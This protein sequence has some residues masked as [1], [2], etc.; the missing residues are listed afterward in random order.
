MAGEIKKILLIFFEEHFFRANLSI[1]TKKNYK[2]KEFTTG[3]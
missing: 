2:I 1:L 3:H